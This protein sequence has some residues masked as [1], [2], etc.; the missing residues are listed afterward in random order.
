M[1]RY[2]FLKEQIKPE[3]KNCGESPGQGNGIP[4][5]FISDPISILMSLCDH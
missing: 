4:E 5:S 3:E 2:A 1:D